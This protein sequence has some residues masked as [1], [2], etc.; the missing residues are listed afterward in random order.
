MK[1]TIFGEHMTV[2]NAIENYINEKFSHLH[3]PEKITHAEFRLG[4][5]KN[6]K[7]VHF[8]ANI[9]GETLIIKSKDENLYHAIDLTMKK[10]H[11]AFIKE[12]GKHHQRLSAHF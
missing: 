2:T 5:T 9:P 12:K 6:D 3:T 7:Y 8:H 10:I 1:I 4:S 11:L